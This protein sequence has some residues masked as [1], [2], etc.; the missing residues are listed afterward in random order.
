MFSVPYFNGP[1]FMFAAGSVLLNQAMSKF[2]NNLRLYYIKVYIRHFNAFVKQTN[3][4][5]LAI[6]IISAISLNVYSPFESLRKTVLCHMYRIE[7]CTYTAK[8]TILSLSRLAGILFQ[9][10]IPIP[11][12]MQNLQPHSTVRT[13]PSTK[14]LIFYCFSNITRRFRD[15]IYRYAIN[16]QI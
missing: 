10:D 7:K 4:V 15:V 3:L 16:Q 14:M 5:R 13:A 12:A 6:P 11:K 1:L 2:Y 9:E 8:Q